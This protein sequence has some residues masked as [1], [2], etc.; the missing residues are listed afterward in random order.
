MV[1][2]QAKGGLLP[3]HRDMAGAA[4]QAFCATTAAYDRWLGKALAQ[5][6]KQYPGLLPG[7][8]GLLKAA[9]MLALLIKTRS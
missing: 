4:A 7:L 8:H 1:E 6:L 9:V 2:L 5:E 3:C